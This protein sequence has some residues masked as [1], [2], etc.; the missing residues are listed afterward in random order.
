MLSIKYNFTFIKSLFMKVEVTFSPSEASREFLKTRKGKALW[1]RLEFLNIQISGLEI[2]L[3][4]FLKETE[5][6][7]GYEI[8]EKYP[9]YRPFMKAYFQL[10]AYWR[11]QDNILNL[12][13]NPVSLTNLTIW[14]RIRR[15]LKGLNSFEYYIED[16]KTKVEE[17]A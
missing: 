17:E 5:N 1:K 4:T 3:D 14:E 11:E 16:I 15:K 13:N 10:V 7:N 2:Y 6:M 12:L 8:A 9:A